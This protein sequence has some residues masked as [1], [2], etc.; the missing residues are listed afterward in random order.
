MVKHCQICHRELFTNFEYNIKF[1]NA[2]CVECAE[3]R[4]GKLLIDNPVKSVFFDTSDEILLIIA[5]IITCGAVFLFIRIHDTSFSLI[6]PIF[7]RI[8]MFDVCEL[9]KHQ[10]WYHVN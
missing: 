1:G 3:T 2:L 4:K 6:H 9:G 10:S 8:N 5:I 7:R